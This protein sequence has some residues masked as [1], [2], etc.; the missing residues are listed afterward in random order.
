MFTKTG[1][2]RDGIQAT[3]TW[4]SVLTPEKRELVPP[5]GNRQREA[6]DAWGGLEAG[7]ADWFKGPGEEGHVH[8]GS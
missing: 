2:A 3:V 7:F 4:P 5:A 8:Q 6:W 1:R